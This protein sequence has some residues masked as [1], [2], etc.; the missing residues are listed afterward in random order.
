VPYRT[1]RLG[2]LLAGRPARRTKEFVSRNGEFTVNIALV[3][4][5]RR[6]SAWSTH[7]SR[8]LPTR[9]GAPRP[10]R[11]TRQGREPI[12]SAQ[13]APAGTG[14]GS[15][16]TPARAAALPRQPGRVRARQHG[17]S[18]KLCLVADGTRTSTRGSARP[19]MGHRGARPCRGAGGRVTT[20]LER[21]RYNAKPELLNRIPVFGDSSVDWT[22]YLD[23]CDSPP[24]AHPALL[25][26]GLPARRTSSRGRPGVR[27]APLASRSSTRLVQGELP[28]LPHD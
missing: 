26:P 17:S 13:P 11:R 7:R 23:G 16:S 9:R 4:G 8:R 12:A 28:R 10:A 21:L 18:L 3:E 22:R 19:R 2:A 6:I 25:M 5:Q 15:R 24:P 27:H 1:R 14:V 20:P